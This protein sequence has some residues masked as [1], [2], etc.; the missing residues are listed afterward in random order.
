M[1]RRDFIAGLGAAAAWPA[2]ARAQQTARRARIGLFVLGD[3]PPA[4]DLELVRELRRLGYVEGRNVEYVVRGSR[5]GGP[6][7]IAAVV[8]ELIASKPD[9]V[10]GPGTAFVYDLAEATHDIPIVVTAVADPVTTGLSSSMARPSRNITGF[11]ISSPSIV[12]KRLEFVRDLLPDVQ[13]VGRLFVLAAVR[14]RRSLTLQ[15]DEQADKAASALGIKLVPMPLKSGAD[16]AEA[17]AT[18]DREK[19]SAIVSDPDPLTAQFSA[20]IADECLVRD[21]PLIHAWSSQVRN[22]ALIGYGPATIE[23]FKGAA[24]YVDRILKGAKVADLPFEEPTQLQLA[25][26]LRTA[27]SIGITVPPKLLALADEVVE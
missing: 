1:R 2:S 25:I 24:G 4:A 7:Q 10:A 20:R 23:N 9:V 18:A 14:A 21:L 17:F 22:G 16:V 27:R 6:D 26:N 5:E 12:S 8:R 19:V 13:K 15:L 3:P 11:T